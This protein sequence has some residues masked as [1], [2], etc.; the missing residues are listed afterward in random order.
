MDRSK[1]SQPRTTQS[2]GRLKENSLQLSSVAESRESLE[3]RL[4]ETVA[5]VEVVRKSEQAY[6]EKSGE[7]RDTCQYGVM[8]HLEVSVLIRVAC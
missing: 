2:T 7:V 1:F 4:A 8:I 3:K 5:E 6:K